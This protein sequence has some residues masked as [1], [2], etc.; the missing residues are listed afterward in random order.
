M[1][2]RVRFTPTMAPSVISDVM[3]TVLLSSNS[4]LNPPSPSVEIKSLDARAIEL[5]LSFR[6]T[7][8]ALSPKT[9]LLERLTGIKIG[10]DLG[11][12]GGLLQGLFGAPKPAPQPTP[13]PVP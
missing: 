8:P 2:L 5:E 6:V 13:Q 7:G 10:G 3:R 12:I 11:G 4:I 9:D 1:K